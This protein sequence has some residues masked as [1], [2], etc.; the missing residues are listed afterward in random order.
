MA[1]KARAGEPATKARRLSRDE[2]DRIRAKE[3]A[4]LQKLHPTATITV[5]VK[6]ETD[7]DGQPIVSH[8]RVPTT[9]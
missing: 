2:M 5:V 9:G 8:V 1:Q 4:H 6:S 7:D 3:L